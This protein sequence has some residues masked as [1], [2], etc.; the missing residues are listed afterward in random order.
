[1][2]RIW[3]AV[4]L[5]LLPATVLACSGSPATKT[6]VERSYGAPSAVR[7]SGE[8]AA[9]ERVAAY[10]WLREKDAIYTYAVDADGTVLSKIDGIALMTSRGLTRLRESSTPVKSTPCEYDAEGNQL[11]AGKAVKRAPGH[12]TNIALAAPTGGVETITHAMSAESTDYTRD[13]E[14]VASVGPYLF[15]REV[16]T[17]VICGMAHRY[18]NTNDFVYDVEGDV[19]TRIDPS[20]EEVDKLRKSADYI[21]AHGPAAIDAPVYDSAEVTATKPGWKNDRLALKYRM[22]SVTCDTCGDGEYS[23]YTRSVSLDAPSIPKELEAYAT[24]PAGV[25]ALLAAHPDAKLGGFT[26]PRDSGY[27]VTI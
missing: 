23:T 9:H 21:L 24:V 4:L 11:P 10:A 19:V 25:K 15:V 17:S 12:I 13:A 26:L 16:G 18:V 27:R 2:P 8:P 6:T 5:A 14:V 7:A 3:N 20:S 1:M 22:S